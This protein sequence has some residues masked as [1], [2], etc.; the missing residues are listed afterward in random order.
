MDRQGANEV[1]RELKV[2]WPIR[3]PETMS[4]D[5]AKATV[6]FIEES[7]ID[8]A[9]DT[10]IKAC[11]SLARESDAIPSW[12]VIKAEAEKTKARRRPSGYKRVTSFAADPDGWLYAIYDDGSC[13]WIYDGARHKWKNDTV[14][15]KAEKILG[16]PAW[17]DWTRK[18]MPKWAS[19]EL[20]ARYEGEIEKQMEMDRRSK[21][22]TSTA[23]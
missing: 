18:Y 14:Q 20:L 3:F 16:S 19:P 12:A 6:D 8:C 10:V 7:F 11:R 13:D 1:F 15:A 21:W 4:E 2:L 17:E 5:K 22:T 23:L 9:A